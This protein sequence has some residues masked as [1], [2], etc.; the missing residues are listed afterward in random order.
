[1]SWPRVALEGEL[2]DPEQALKLG[3]VDEVV[4][5]NDI[6]KYMMAFA[7]AAYQN[8]KSICP[9]HHMMLPRIIK[10]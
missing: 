7:G 6:R 10:G 5:M 3:L 4:S 8:P 2:F 9:H 1:M